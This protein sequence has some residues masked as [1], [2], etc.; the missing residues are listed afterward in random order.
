MLFSYFHSTATVYKSHISLYT[1]SLLPSDTHLHDRKFRLTPPKKMV[2]AH[3]C[4]SGILP[5]FSVYFMLV[6]PTDAFSVDMQRQGMSSMKGCAA[7]QRSPT[8]SEPLRPLL[9]MMVFT[10][11]GMENFG[12]A[13]VVVSKP[14]VV[15]GAGT[16]PSS[17]II[18]DVCSFHPDAGGKSEVE[19]TKYMS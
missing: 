4:L 6:V 9:N 5:L 15:L 19:H 17:L 10:V 18:K 13:P 16:K 14:V 3:S 2:W 7:L 12:V 8:G 11:A 1:T